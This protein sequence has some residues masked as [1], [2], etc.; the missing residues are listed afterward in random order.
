[1]FE[2]DNFVIFVQVSDDSFIAD[3][4]P[5]ENVWN[6]LTRFWNDTYNEIFLTIIFELSVKWYL[7]LLR[8]DGDSHLPIVM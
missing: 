2:I 1:M 5:G 7:S 8:I 3:F 4:F 6:K